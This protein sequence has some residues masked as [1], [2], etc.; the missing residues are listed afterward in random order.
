MPEKKDNKNGVV[1]ETFDYQNTNNNFQTAS[2]EDLIRS[3]QTPFLFEDLSSAEQQLN[4]LAPSSSNQQQQQQPESIIMY[5][6]NNN[7]QFYMDLS[8]QYLMNP[9]FYLDQQQQYPTNQPTQDDL[10]DDFLSTQDFSNS[11]PNPTHHTVVLTQP[12]FN[13]PSSVTKDQQNYYTLTHNAAFLSQQTPTKMYSMPFMSQTQSP[14]EHFSAAVDRLTSLNSIPSPHDSTSLSSPSVSMGSIS[15]A[16]NSSFVFNTPNDVG[17]LI[18]LV[19]GFNKPVKEKQLGGRDNTKHPLPRQVVELSA[20]QLPPGSNPAV[21][22]VRAVVMGTDRVT[23][24]SNKLAVL[25]EKPFVKIGSPPT[26]RWV[27][28]FDDIIIQFASHNNGQKLSLRFELLDAEKKT[29]CSIDSHG[30]ETITKRG[31]EKLKERKAKD[32]RKRDS[33]GEDNSND[34]TVEHVNPAFGFTSGGALVKVIGTGFT[35]TPLD[36]CIVKFGEKEAREIHTVKRNYIVCET[37]EG[38]PGMVDVSVSLDRESFLQS[39]AKFCYIDPTNPQDVQNMIQIMLGD[40]MNMKTQSPNSSTSSKCYDHSLFLSGKVADECGFTVLHHSCAN[41][42][43]ELTKHLVSE[44]VCDLETKDNFGRT[45]LHWATFSSSDI[46]ALYLIHQGADITSRDEVGDSFL[47]VACRYSSTQFVKNVLHFLIKFDDKYRTKTSNILDLLTSTNNDG[48]TPIDLLRSMEQDDQ[49]IEMIDLFDKFTTICQSRLSDYKIQELK[50]IVLRSGEH[51]GKSLSKLEGESDISIDLQLNKDQFVLV[52]NRADAQIR[53]TIEYKHIAF[54]ILSKA[55][56][57][58]EITLNAKPTIEIKD[59]NS[60]WT[61]LNDHKYLS[62]CLSFNLE[63]GDVSA[64]EKINKFICENDLLF[65]FQNMCFCCRTPVDS[66]PTSKEPTTVNKTTTD[67]SPVVPTTVTSKLS[68]LT[69]PISSPPQTN[70][71][72]NVNNNI[73]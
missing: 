66:T 28:T 29:V 73:F 62:S 70:E 26:E 55:Q 27:A 64:L 50:D 60:S 21:I 4:S 23:R 72:Q 30:F 47:H 44:D 59:A 40:Q 67:K 71:K 39:N 7:P 33:D 2:F 8:Q 24:K 9:N 20:K 5:A 38:E 43:Y 51:N 52:I 22:S 19:E 36:K 12:S 58:A 35:I 25:H 3:F 48:V 61:P 15:P 53:A 10:G 69:K 17:N 6:N 18:R 13:I 57:R 11:Q 49:V 34:A 31:I 54:L 65:Q 16:L 45:A 42:Y 37:P 41:G 68:Q 32:K 46:I 63:V 1:D 14:S 56:L